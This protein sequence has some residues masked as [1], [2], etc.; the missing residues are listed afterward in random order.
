[1]DHLPVPPVDAQ[2]TNMVC[3]FCIVGCGYHVYKWPVGK[4]GG[5]APQQNALGLDFRQQLPP[6]RLILTPAMVN[7]VQDA[8][9]QR[10]QLMI[11]PDHACTVNQG[12]S[13]TRGGHLAN[14]MYTGHGASANRLQ[15]P[16]FFT[17]DQWLETPW[18]QALALYAGVTRKILDHDGPDQLFFNVFDHGG[19]GGGF[20]NTWGTGKLLFTALR[21]K[22][23][24]IHNRPAYNSECHASRDMGISE[25]NNS[26]EDA[27][28]AD[29]ILSSGNNPYETQ[30]NYFLAHWV[31]NLQGHTVAKKRQRFADETVAAAKIIFVDPRRTPSVAVAEQVAGKANVLHLDLNP[32][33]DTALFNALLTYVVDQGWHARD[34]IA[35]HTTGFEETVK[36]NRLSLHQASEITGLPVAKI[37]QAAEWAYKP[38]DS[39][40]PPRTMHV[41]EKGIIWGNDNYRV[42]SALVDLALA[43]YNVGRRGA[44]ICRMG[45]HQEGYAR[46]PY[47]GPRPAPYIDQEIIKGN[48]KMLTVWACN[49]FQTTCNAEQYRQVVL[50]RAGIVR[51]AMAQARGATSEQ[52][53]EIIYDAVSHKGGLFIATV[54]L[55]PTQFATSGHLILPSVHPGEMNLTSMNGERRMRLSEKFM[56]PPGSAKPD[57]LIA[58]AIAN[59]LK[60]AYT[61]TGN[62][63]MAQ[64]FAGFDWHTEEDAFND[65]FR[66]P[67]G[68]D[69]Q[70]GST[71]DLVTYERL[72]AMGNDGVQL[73][74]KEYKDGK[75]IGTEMLYTDGKFST[76][77]GKA[78]FQ[79]SPWNGL[80]AP[81]QA[82]KDKYRFWVNNGRTNHIWQTAYHDRYIDFRKDRYPMAPLE[83][84]PDDAKALGISDGDVVEVYNDYGSTYAM[85]YLEPAIKHDQVFMMFGYPFGIA[86]DVTTAAVDRNVVPYYKGTWADLRRIGTMADYRQRVTF[87]SRRFI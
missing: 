7:T 78:H 63:D 12:L 48:G 46:P 41:Y 21:T 4:D 70:G 83:I 59:T 61:S 34:F 9:G 53:V 77:D 79:P 19:A 81:V 47:P 68:I 35:R 36:A 44:G 50:H 11:V 62:S 1:M 17:G 40:H 49:A 26:Y 58:A 72:R 16:Q 25:L 22:M 82:E 80:L 75:L 86:G 27:E 55:Y 28:L 23:V 31:P 39:G 54:D 15:N 67:E 45:G 3:H 6:L 87:K 2:K 24:R 32:G 38:K 43:T 33:T 85:A 29:V 5:R 57:C 84:N 73:P 30:T 13:S 74:A 18:E 56:E 10:Y 65:G 14:V 8:D 66:H 69:S 52:M 20:E 42:Q 64:R 60:A 37:K 76:Q 51:E 71:G